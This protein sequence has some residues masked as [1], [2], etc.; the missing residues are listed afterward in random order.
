VEPQPNRNERRRLAALRARGF[1]EDEIAEV[2]PR[3]RAPRPVPVTN[4]PLLDSRAVCGHLGGISLMTL[5]RFGKDRDFPPP[6]L[7]IGQRRRFWRLSSIDRWIESQMEKT[8][9]E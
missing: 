4:D 2:T 3:H 5:W 1:T 6:D 8:P 9:T 7:R